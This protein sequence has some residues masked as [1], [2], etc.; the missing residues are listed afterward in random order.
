M[1]K[2]EE[3]LD[4][5]LR[6][7][8]IS[9]FLALSKKIV[10]PG[11]DG[12]PLYNVTVFFIAGLRKGYIT[13]RASAISFTFF[14]AIFPSL[15][16]LFTIIPFIPIDNFQQSLLTLIRDFYRILLMKR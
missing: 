1:I 12:I 10:L 11:F 13:S 9:F 14:L 6:W 4:Q 8:V 15:I 5:V 3:I 16:F 7:K 2:P